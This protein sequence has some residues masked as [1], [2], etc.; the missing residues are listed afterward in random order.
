ML[1]EVLFFGGEALTGLLR[2]F[3]SLA[4]FLGVRVQFPILGGD[5]RDL[6]KEVLFFSGKA[7]AG[8]L[9]AFELFRKLV[10]V[11][12][13]LLIEP[14]DLF[15]QDPVSFLKGRHQAL[16][17]N[18]LFFEPFVFLDQGRVVGRASGQ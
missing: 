2:A 3:E 7:L 6:L 4:Q 15:L 12:P 11:L 10:L 1:K 5:G 13:K 18:D 9:R 16:L 17:F 8:L 14:I